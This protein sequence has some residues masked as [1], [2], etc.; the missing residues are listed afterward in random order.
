MFELMSNKGH[1]VA[2]RSFVPN[3]EQSR[4]MQEAGKR[5][6]NQKF[7]KL[8]FLHRNK[9]FEFTLKS[10]TLR[11]TLHFVSLLIFSPPSGHQNIFN[12]LFIT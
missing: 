10:R 5:Q 3:G 9:S 11:L 1:Q 4:W 12:F 6:K 8:S 7:S 2:A